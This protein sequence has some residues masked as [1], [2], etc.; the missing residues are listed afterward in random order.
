M[1]LETSLREF[2]RLAGLA[3]E[4]GRNMAEFTSMGVG[5]AAAGYLAPADLSQSGRALVAARKLGLPVLVAGLGTN[6]IVLEGGIKGLVVHLA[7][8][9]DK[10]SLDDR[11]VSAEAGCSLPKLCKLVAKAGLTGLEFCSGIPGTLGGAVAQNAGWKEHQIGELVQRVW[12]FDEQGGLMPLSREEAGFG[13]RT[14]RFKREGLVVAQVELRL[15]AGDPEV[16]QRQTCE[17]AHTRINTQPTGKSA[18]SV[19]KNPPGDVAGRL[20][21]LAGAKEL[22]VGRAHISE[23]HANFIVNEG[24]ATGAD[25]VKLMAKAAELVLERSGILLEPEVEVLAALA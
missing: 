8:H 6:L 16:I 24:G 22:G 13:Y 10:L 25:I 3:L 7:P 5:G 14:S 1:Q 15:A 18:G 20:L 12:I 11:T 17:Y 19:F 2:E 21:D 9:L 23:R 4:S